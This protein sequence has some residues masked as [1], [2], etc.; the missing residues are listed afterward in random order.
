MEFNASDVQILSSRSIDDAL[1]NTLVE[2]EPLILAL[3]G[4]I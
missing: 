4:L 2:V 3:F 1:F